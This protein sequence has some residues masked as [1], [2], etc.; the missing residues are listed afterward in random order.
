[1]AYL[2]RNQPVSKFVLNEYNN[3]KSLTLNGVGTTRVL[4]D[5]TI[6]NCVIDF[7]TI[8]GAQSLYTITDSK[9]V[10]DQ[11]IEQSS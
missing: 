9:R 6:V 1:M 11:R 5:N 3:D 10:L 8:A 2:F 4:D 7:L